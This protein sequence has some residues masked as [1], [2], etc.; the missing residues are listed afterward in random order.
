MS[1]QVLILNE[2][3]LDG[4]ASEADRHSTCY[5]AASKKEKRELAPELQAKLSTGLIMP[6]NRGK[7]RK[8]SEAR[9]LETINRE[10]GTI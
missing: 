2:L 9:V 8:S 6:G 1:A 10:S 4:L 5:L 7:S 3:V